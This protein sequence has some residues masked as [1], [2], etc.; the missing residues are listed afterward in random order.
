MCSMHL[1][2][3][4]RVVQEARRFLFIVGEIISSEY[5]REGSQE[6]RV[7]ASVDIQNAV[8]SELQNLTLNLD[9][10]PKA[11]VAQSRHLA[12]VLAGGGGVGGGRFAKFI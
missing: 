9:H 12:V 1:I 11:L 6:F 10:T 4:P 3:G 8:S 7:K 2:R 5:L